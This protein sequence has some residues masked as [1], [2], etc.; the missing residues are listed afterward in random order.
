MKIDPRF[1]NK[2]DAAKINKLIAKE[3]PNRSVCLGINQWKYEE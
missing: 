2:Q 1:T 3:T